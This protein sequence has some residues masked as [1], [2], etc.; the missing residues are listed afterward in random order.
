MCGEVTGTLLPRPRARSKSSSY[1]SRQ[2]SLRQRS[3]PPYLGLVAGRGRDWCVILLYNHGH[4]SRPEIESEGPNRSR[5]A[6]PQPGQSPEP[7]RRVKLA[8]GP[9][10]YTPESRA[11]SVCHLPLP[12][13]LHPWLIVAVDRTVWSGE[14][15]E[16]GRQYRAVAQG[17]GAEPAV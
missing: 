10:G 6:V 14:G 16:P 8:R 13:T 5:A 4:Q 12:S 15:R 11:G 17:V 1:A 2:F 7:L 3:R 9:L